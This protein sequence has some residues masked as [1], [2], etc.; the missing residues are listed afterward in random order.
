VRQ[1][2][3]ATARTIIELLLPDTGSLRHQGA[4]IYER[5]GEVLRDA[6]LRAI[7]SHNHS[8]LEAQVS[9]VLSATALAPDPGLVLALAEGR[10]LQWLAS[11]RSLSTL[12]EAVAGDLFT[13]PQPPQR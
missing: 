2:L 8:D 6:D 1:S 4:V 10:L 9:R 7:V 13:L 12:V 11:D 3:R 5:L